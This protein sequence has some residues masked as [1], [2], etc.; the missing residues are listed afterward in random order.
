MSMKISV[1][2]KQNEL[3]SR[4]SAGGDMEDNEDELPEVAGVVLSLEPEPCT[5]GHSSGPVGETLPYGCPIS[6]FRLRGGRAKVTRSGFLC[7]SSTERERRPAPCEWG[8][9]LLLSL[10][11]RTGCR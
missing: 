1:K 5:N 10:L 7:V 11:S 2:C 8:Q 3:Y 9:D 4:P 6:G